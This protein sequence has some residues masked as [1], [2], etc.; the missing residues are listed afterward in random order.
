[1]SKKRKAVIHETPKYYSLDRILSKEACYNIIFGERSNGKT[2]SVLKYSI[3]HYFETRGQFAIVRRWKEDITGRRAS[4]IFTSIN[5]DGVVEKYSKGKFAGI[6]YSAGKFYACIYDEDGKP[7]YNDT[8]IIG[9]CFSLSDTEHNKSISYPM[10]ETIFF[11]EFLTNKLYLADEF[12]LFMNTISTI[13]RQRDNVKIFMCGN[14]VNKYCPYFKEFGLTHILKM[15]QGDIDVYRYGDSRLVVA[16]EYCSSMN[17]NKK[18]NF[19]FAFDNPKLQMITQGSWEL[20]IYPH[21]PCKYN[22]KQVL[23]EFVIS[24]EGINYLSEVIDLGNGDIILYVHEKTTPIKEKTIVFSLADNP[25]MWYN[26]SISSPNFKAGSKIL[27][28]IKH[29]KIFY[30]NNDVGNAIHNYFKVSGV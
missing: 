22:P 16:V 21:L 12:V 13:V 14:T 2:Y 17:S 1:M 29:H 23:F 20:D 19:Y 25:S 10:I 5:Q 7:V 3:K 6:H 4:D 30:Q 18:S 26:K 9:Y 11:D 24:F 28:L 27:W 8:N 15:N